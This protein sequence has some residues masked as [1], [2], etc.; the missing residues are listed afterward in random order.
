[1][2]R[3]H[4]RFLKTWNLKYDELTSLQHSRYNWRSKITQL[5]E[6]Q[7]P[8][9]GRGSY[10]D[11]FMEFFYFKFN[12][13]NIAFGILIS[14]PISS[15]SWY[16]LHLPSRAKRILNQQKNLARETFFSWDSDGLICCSEIGKTK[17]PWSDFIN[18]KENKKTILIYHSDHLFLIFPKHCFSGIDELNSF[19]SHLLDKLNS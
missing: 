12:R 2:D 18:I 14:I 8:D 15:L 10:F 4:L 13:K 6:D 17:S 3:S 11:L 1:M 9:C 7:S 19:R 16:Y 5:T